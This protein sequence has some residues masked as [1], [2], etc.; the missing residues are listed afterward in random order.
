MRPH[1]PNPTMWSKG[2][3]TVQTEWYSWHLKKY[4]FQKRVIAGMAAWAN[5]NCPSSLFYAARWQGPTQ[6]LLDVHSKDHLALL[7]S[8]ILLLVIG[9][10]AVQRY[11]RL[12][13][14]V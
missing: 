3:D 14:R 4:D 10:V 11:Y 7:V 8:D 13:V 9:L 1:C 6:R 12:S 2:V 5:D